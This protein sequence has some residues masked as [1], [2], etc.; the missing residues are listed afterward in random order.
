[1]HE[2]KDT[3]IPVFREGESNDP[4]AANDGIDKPAALTKQIEALERR[5]QAVR[6]MMKELEE[7]YEILKKRNDSLNKKED[8]LNREYLKLLEIEA[9]YQGTDRLVESLDAILPAGETVNQ[10]ETESSE[11]IPEKTEE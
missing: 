1:M 11:M 3:F 7:A 4:F 2:K 10:D 6:E 5:E 8:M 9:M